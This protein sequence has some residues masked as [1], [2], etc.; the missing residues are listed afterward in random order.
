MD[1]QRNNP[2][3]NTAKV[4]ASPGLADP[5]DPDGLLLNP[6]WNNSG[7]AQAA[8]F[9]SICHPVH[10]V[11]SGAYTPFAWYI[12][13][14]IASAGSDGKPGLL[15]NFSLDT[16]KPNDPNDNI[17]NYLLRFGATGN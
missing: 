1:P 9:E 16:S 7:N 10:R 11:V 8:A 3:G 6:N 5:V 17:Y 4:Q 15:A 14:V 13:P 12:T 2:A